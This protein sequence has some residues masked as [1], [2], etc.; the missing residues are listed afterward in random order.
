[1]GLEDFEGYLK[2]EGYLIQQIW[3]SFN[4]EGIS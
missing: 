3:I 2:I 4:D 1:M